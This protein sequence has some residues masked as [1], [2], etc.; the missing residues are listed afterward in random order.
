M[1]PHAQR[2]AELDRKLKGLSR[3]VQTITNTARERNY[4]PPTPVTSHHQ[5]GRDSPETTFRTTEEFDSDEELENAKLILKK[6]QNDLLS[7]SKL[8]FYPCLT[9]LR[10]K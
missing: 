9:T 6:L 3:A 2:L 1:D 5:S 7:V 10:T 4:I 8:C